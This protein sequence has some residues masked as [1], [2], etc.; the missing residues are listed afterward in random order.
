M[1]L[2]NYFAYDK[3]AIHLPEIKVLIGKDPRS[4]P[5]QLSGK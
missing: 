2:S 1:I 4:Y 3:F 5:M